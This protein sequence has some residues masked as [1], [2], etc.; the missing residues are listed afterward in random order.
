MAA[1]DISGDDDVWT[2]IVCDWEMALT[3]G[4]MEFWASILDEAGPK[5]GCAADRGALLVMFAKE[6]WRLPQQIR[7][8]AFTTIVKSAEGLEEGT[9]QRVLEEAKM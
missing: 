7:Q 1:A 9:V 2:S 4:D 3:D 6:I 5:L 8:N